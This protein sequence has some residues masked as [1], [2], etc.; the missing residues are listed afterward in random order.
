MSIF[1]EI[2]QRQSPQR[3]WQAIVANNPATMDA[4]VSVTIPGLNDEGQQLRW[5]NCRWQA[6]DDISKP[7]R[8]DKCLV[9]FDDNGE[10]W[11]VA[12]WPF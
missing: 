1:E 7:V 11:V 3:A 5:E 8:G 6:R 12:W 10:L 2:S 9:V 4:L